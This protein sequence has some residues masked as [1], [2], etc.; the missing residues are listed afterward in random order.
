V[1]LKISLALLTIFTLGKAAA[2]EPGYLENIDVRETLDSKRTPQP[3]FVTVTKAAG[4]KLEGQIGA[5]IK[6][7]IASAFNA[8]TWLTFGPSIEYHRNTAT[9]KPQDIFEAGL[10][11]ELQPLDLANYAATPVAALKATYKRDG[12]DKTSGYSLAAQ[13]FLLFRGAGK[14]VLGIWKP[15]RLTSLYIADVSY[16]PWI[17]IEHERVFQAKDG[18]PTGHATRIL[19]KIQASIFLLPRWT[20]HKIETLIEYSFRRDALDTLDPIDQKHSLLK[21]SLNWYLLEEEDFSAGLGL[22]FV[23]GEDPTKGLAETQ[24]WMLAAKLRL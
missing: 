5:A 22:D 4:Q 11:A 2:A 20:Q 7:D 24:Y 19:F 15:D 14:D 21:L 8:Q 23:K 3:A 9:K 6:Y 16:I 10:T 12:E 1:K 17:G 18:A 13:E